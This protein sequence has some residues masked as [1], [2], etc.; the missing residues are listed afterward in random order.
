MRQSRST[1]EVNGDLLLTQ[2]VSIAACI[3][4][5]VVSTVAD[6]QLREKRLAARAAV[7]KNA[8]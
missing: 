1:A 6:S 4:S 8:G 5:L 7:E 3:A 2:M